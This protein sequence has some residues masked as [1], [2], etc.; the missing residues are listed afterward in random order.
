MG[1]G[2][3]LTSA[4]TRIFG[5][6]QL[7]ATGTS[8]AVKTAGNI[9]AGITF[10]GAGFVDFSTAVQI[11]TPAMIGVLHGAKIGAKASDRRLKLLF[12]G[13]L[14]VLAPICALAKSKK[15]VEE[16]DSGAVS[17]KRGVPASPLELV[18]RV[19]DQA[20]S[21]PYRAL[22]HLGV[23]LGFGYCTGLLGVGGAPLVMTY[24][25]MDMAGESGQKVV[26]TTLAT[27][28]VPSIVGMG[29]HWRLGTILWPAVPLLMAGSLSGG[30]GGAQAAMMVDSDLIRY[31]FS[32]FLACLGGNTL[33]RAGVAGGAIKIAAKAL[34]AAGK[35]AH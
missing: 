10:A 26:G 5:I 23:G 19:K 33:Y 20:T 8:L 4:L 7:Q 32:G 30:V 29:V 12:G 1:G 31:A 24:L 25:F 34:K 17:A 22:R 11:A 13:L 16:V 14:L 2:I 18:Q 15:D 21:D 27:V 9:S 28:T 3:V 6:T 35:R